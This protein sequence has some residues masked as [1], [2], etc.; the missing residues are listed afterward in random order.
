[1]E[2]NALLTAL[3]DMECD[4]AR[5]ILS[6][7]V[8]GEAEPAETQRSDQHLAGCA[9]CSGW[10]TSVGAVNRAL[11]VRSAEAVPDIATP[12]LL[13]SRETR[14][15]P[16]QTARAS[17][18]VLALIELVF[19]LTGVLAGRDASPIHDSQHLGAFGAAFAA[20]VLF[21]AWRPGR[22]RGLMPLAL[23]LAIAIPVF[24]IID[25]A[26]ENLTTGGGIHHIAQMVGL[27]LVW[28]VSG[29]PARSER[30]RESTHRTT[31]RSGPHVVSAG[32]TQR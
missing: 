22:A 26:N 11:R 13:R 5:E 2:L 9:S 4:A 25:L 31:D 1:M 16:R 19:A 17:L 30:E 27:A 21:V 6:A 20:A 15:W 23:T 29:H 8:D 18:A 14:R 28:V 3:V 32:R 12:A 10:W 24:A 7:R